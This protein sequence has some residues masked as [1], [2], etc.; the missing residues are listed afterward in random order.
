MRRANRVVLFVAMVA[1]LTFLG[2][3]IWYGSVV[4]RLYR[5][6][7]HSIGMSDCSQLGVR[8]FEDV[9]SG[10]RASAYQALSSAYRSRLTQSQ[11]ETY[12]DEYPLLN[13]HRFVNQVE[14]FG[15]A[16]RAD[17]PLTAVRIR[18]RLMPARLPADD[19]PN[20]EA[21]ADPKT[22]RRKLDL[23]LHFVEENGNWFIDQITF[24]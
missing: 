14:V 11:F 3:S 8:F 21:K 5:K 7:N 23:T 1:A 20:E 24:P 22:N 13:S 18:Y 2:L 12:L 10:R 4:Y 9:R 15:M 17:Q 19:E 16:D 6:P